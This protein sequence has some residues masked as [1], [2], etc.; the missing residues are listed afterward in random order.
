MW[1]CTATTLQVHRLLH[2]TSSKLTMKMWTMKLASSLGNLYM[3]T[4]NT[5]LT[6]NW[7]VEVVEIRWYSNKV[8]F[9]TQLQ[10]ARIVGTNLY[11]VAQV[12]H[13][14]NNIPQD[15]Q[16]RHVYTGLHIHKYTA[17]KFQCSKSLGHK[18][19]MITVQ[20]KITTRTSLV[21][22]RINNLINIKN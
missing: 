17:Q 10:L 13:P 3:Q 6:P 19:N 5:I 4:V 9:D 7:S 16:C 15:F 11:K 12:L 18:Y 21:W 1:F 20:Y 22:Q 8:G 14:I 2:F